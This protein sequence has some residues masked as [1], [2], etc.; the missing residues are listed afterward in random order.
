LTVTVQRW[1]CSASAIASGMAARRKLTSTCR[2]SWYTP[3]EMRW[4]RKHGSTIGTHSS[5]SVIHSCNQWCG[6]VTWFML[7]L[8]RQTSDSKRAKHPQ[9]QLNMV[10][11]CR[12]MHTNVWTYRLSR[13][14]LKLFSSDFQFS[15]SA[16]R[17][18][19]YVHVVGC[20]TMVSEGF[21]L[22]NLPPRLASRRSEPRL[23]TV[24]RDGSPAC[25]RR[26]GSV[27]L[28]V[29]HLPRP[30]APPMRTGARGPESTMFL[31][32]SAGEGVLNDTA[33][34]GL[35]GCTRLLTMFLNCNTAEGLSTGDTLSATHL[36]SA[37]EHDSVCRAML[38]PV[39]RPDGM[40]RSLFCIHQHPMRVPARF[41]HAEES[42]VLG[43][44]ACM[45]ACSR[46]G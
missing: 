33:A 21:P 24:S 2:I 22:L 46:A 17:P 45:R 6:G 15:A 34:P 30:T 1:Q 32:A 37:S 19:P 12:N 4:T 36:I 41:K 8:C 44:Q 20:I 5:D 16:R 35:R 31:A 23:G 14:R 29:P 43:F 28:A 27:F 42:C 7:L 38:Q 9:T 13:P 26:L 25:S 3:P 39:Y 11:R 40:L 18:P 10:V